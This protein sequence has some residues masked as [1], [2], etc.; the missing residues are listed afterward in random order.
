V[1][2]AQFTGWVD[3]ETLAGWFRASSLLLFPS[4]FD[5]FGCAVLEALSCG[6]PVACYPVKGPADLVEDEVNGL[7]CADPKHMGE[8]V[9]AY[10]QSSSAR[11]ESFRQQCLETARRY[12]ADK[13]MDQML[14][15]IG[16]TEWSNTF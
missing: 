7:L 16:L 6:L 1:P 5:T 10:L 13:I 15:N 4:R 12:R 8:R 9:V 2:E 14:A 3:R 11:Q